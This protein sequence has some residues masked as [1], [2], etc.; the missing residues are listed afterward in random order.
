MLTLILA[1]G[2]FANDWPQWRGPNRDGVVAN[3]PAAWPKDLKLKW[4][5]PTGAGYASPV[6]SQGAAFVFSRD[7]SENETLARF[8]L[9]NGK[10][11]WTKSYTAPF[12]K[13]SYAK[14]MSKGPFSTPLV[15]DNRVYTLGVTAI[16]SAWDLKSGALLWRKDFS[17]SVD[18]SKLF[19]GTA[20]SPVVEAGHLIVHTGDDRGGLVH[21]FDPATGA[22]RWKLP[23]AAGPGYASPIA[24]AGQIVT[25]T[26]QSVVGINAAN[27]KLL[28]TF[29][30][31]DEWLENIITPIRF[32]DLVILSGVRRGT[33]AIRITPN[34]AQQ[35][36]ANP[37]AAFYMS[38]PVVDGPHLYGLGSKKK[39]QFLCLDGRS[40]KIVWATN[41]REATQAAVLNA[42]PHILWTTNDGDLVV[43]KKSA[44][45][46]EQVTRYSVSDAPVWTVPVLLGRQILI[47]SDNSLA[48]WSLD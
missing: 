11:E 45:A 21:A 29:P 24:V 44:K 6:V 5:V 10:P 2:V 43:S 32:E 38:T 35:A 9:A 27:G 3:A 12:K 8:N 4:K 18:T 26:D 31:K 28:W 34:G 48:L 25:M 46:F 33:V 47:K 14:D 42:G 40:G 23:M 37:E 41:G 20:M 19:T 22:E 17:K 1:V 16:L 15:K 30:W 7:A 36:W 13:N 39:G